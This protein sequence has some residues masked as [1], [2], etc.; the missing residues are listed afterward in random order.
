MFIFCFS[1]EEEFWI[2]ANGSGW[3]E[4]IMDLSGIYFF[5]FMGFNSELE[6]EGEEKDFFI[7]MMEGLLQFEF[8]DIL[9]CFFDMVVWEFEK[10]GKNLDMLLDSFEFVDINEVGIMEAEKEVNFKL[11]REMINIQLCMQVK[12]FEFLFKIIIINIFDDIVEFKQGGNFME[13]MMGMDDY[14]VMGG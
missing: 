11:F 1:N 10:E 6:E 9:I 7:K 5:I 8:V 13:M 14:V 12:K 4:F 3:Y 2:E